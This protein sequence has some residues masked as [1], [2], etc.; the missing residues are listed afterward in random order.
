M[1]DKRSETIPSS[2][3]TPDPLD[4]QLHDGGASL[5]FTSLIFYRLQV[6]GLEWQKLG[7]VLSDTFL[8]CF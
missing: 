1:P 2:R 7:F 5:Q 8:C 3:I 4:S 6:R